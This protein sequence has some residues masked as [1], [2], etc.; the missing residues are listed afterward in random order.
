MPTKINL[1]FDDL[2]RAGLR[3]PLK[4]VAVP[5]QGEPLAEGAAPS[6]GDE[7]AAAA[8]KPSRKPGG[9]AKRKRI[10]LAR[11]VSS[12]CESWVEGRSRQGMG[13][14][15]KPGARAS[16]PPLQTHRKSPKML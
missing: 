1:S 3:V 2:L 10:R 11:A 4:D 16:R 12:Y 14:A 5:G 9:K 6:G 15:G 8:T 13:R 7:G